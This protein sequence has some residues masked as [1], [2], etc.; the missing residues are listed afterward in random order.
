MTT[1]PHQAAAGS[2]TPRAMRPDG[3]EISLWEV[4]DVLLR[5]RGTI[6]LAAVLMVGLAVAFTLTR[7]DTY[8]TVALFRPQG[9]EA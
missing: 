7:A 1:D 8:T 6:V 5:R 2:G 9:S 4:L 3:D